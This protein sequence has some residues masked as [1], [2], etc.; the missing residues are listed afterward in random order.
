MF[1]IL[2]GQF[3]IQWLLYVHNTFLTC[4]FFLFIAV[5]YIF[6]PEYRSYFF[7]VYAA[8]FYLTPFS[9]VYSLLVSFLH[10][11]TTVQS[12]LLSIT[13]QNSIFP[14]L[15]RLQFSMPHL[16]SFCPSLVHDSLSQVSGVDS[17]IEL[18]H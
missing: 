17:A 2:H 10:F 5:L 8:T 11:S 16:R 6:T 15:W 3:H 13:H 12:S 14:S 9:V 1:R 4:F 18:L 7:L